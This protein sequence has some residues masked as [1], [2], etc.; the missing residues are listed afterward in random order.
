MSTPENQATIEELDGGGGDGGRPACLPTQAVKQNH[1]H[2]N[3]SFT[4]SPLTHN[5]FLPF[6]VPHNI[7]PFLLSIYLLSLSSNLSISNSRST[8][9][10]LHPII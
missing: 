5:T 10:I 2:N 9:G 1:L 3:S 7:L 6:S 4:F 8:N